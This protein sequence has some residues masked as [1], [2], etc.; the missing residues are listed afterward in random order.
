MDNVE[1]LLELSDLSFGAIR[2]ADSF[3]EGVYSTFDISLGPGIHMNCIS[4]GFALHRPGARGKAEHITLN[5]LVEPQVFHIVN[6]FPDYLQER[7]NII[8]RLMEDVSTPIDKIRFEIQELRRIVS[9]LILA[10]EKLYE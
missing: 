7:V 3:K 2:F 4:Y 5:L 1:K 9:R 6:Q 10:Y 8:R